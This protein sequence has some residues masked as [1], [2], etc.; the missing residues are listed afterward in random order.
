MANNETSSD[1]NYST[2]KSGED[3]ILIIGD[4]KI[5]LQGAANL[6]EINIS[7]YEKI[8]CGE[9]TDVICNNYRGGGSSIIFEDGG[10]GD[11]LIYNHENFSTEEDNA[12]I[13]KNNW[14]Q[15]DNRSPK[16]QF[17]LQKRKQFHGRRRR[18]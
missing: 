5:I 6:S 11:D 2:M 15:N 3:I 16:R 7:P 1:E 8:I 13:W 14:R 9:G 17:P 12:Y 4:E 18:R 10:D